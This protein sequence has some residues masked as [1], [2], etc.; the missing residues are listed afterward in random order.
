ML[1]SSKRMDYFFSVRIT[2][3]LLHFICNYAIEQYRLCS[4]SYIACFSC[5]ACTFKVNYIWSIRNNDVSCQPAELTMV[6]ARYVE[7]E[8]LLKNSRCYCAHFALC[9]FVAS[10]PVNDALTSDKLHCNQILCVP[11]KAWTYAF[12]VCHFVQACFVVHR[13]S[14]CVCPSYLER[15][16][17]A[18]C[19]CLHYNPYTA[20]A[21]YMSAIYYCFSAQIIDVIPSDSI[22]IIRSLYFRSQ[23][24]GYDIR[25]MSLD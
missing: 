4:G 24:R 11:F 6:K 14:V 12:A 19:F 15:T 3:D 16:N 8:A 7:A 13:L 25:G 17:F 1:V 20:L 9:S 22:S 18:P 2:Q 21:G 10:C 23:K 5:G